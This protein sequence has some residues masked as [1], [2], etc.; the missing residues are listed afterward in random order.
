MTVLETAYLLL[1]MGLWPIPITPINDPVSVA[2]GKAP[3]PFKDW[4]K[5]KYTKESLAEVYAAFPAA[6]IGLK[7]GPEGKIIDIDVDDPAVG[8]PVV[9]RMMGGEVIETVGWQ[10][11]R[12]PHMVFWF[13][14]RLT[15]YGKS[16]IKD[17]PRYP[18]LELRFG[19]SS[20]GPVQIQSV[21]P[22]SLGNNG[23]PRVW[24]GVQ[25][26]AF[27]P[28]AFFNDLD[29][30]L[31]DQQVS[32]FTPVETV[33]VASTSSGS[34]PGTA[35]VEWA[36]TTTVDLEERAIAYLKK[37]NPSISGQKGH[38][39][40]FRIACTIGPGFDLP[41]DVA[42]RLLRDVWNPTCQPPWSEKELRHK[43]E[44]A[45][46]VESRPRGWL[47]DNSALLTTNGPLLA[48]NGIR[49]TS[50]STTTSG[51]IG[52]IDPINPRVV[53]E[54]EEEWE[55]PILDTA[56][57]VEPFPLDVLPSSLADLCRAGAR[58]LNCPVDYFAVAAL[59]LAGGVIGRTV[60]LKMTTTWELTANL[61]IAIV[62]PPGSK[63]SP[64][65]KIMAGPLFAIDRQLRDDYKEAKKN[66]KALPEDDRGPEPVLEHLTLDDTT[67]EAF[68]KILSDNERGLLLIKDELTAWV[69]DLNAY[70]GGKGSDRQFWMG[71]NTGSLVKVTRKG[72][73]EPLVIPHP[74]GAVV[75]CLTPATLPHIKEGQG[76]DGWLD[77]ILFA[78]PKTPRLAEEWNRYEV[79]QELLDEWRNAVG[80]LWSRKMTLDEGAT[81][82]RPWLVSLT[83]NGESRWS[84]FFKT[85]SLEQQDIDFPTS[86]V[87]PWSKYVGFTLRLSLVLSQL[88]QAYDP[89][90]Y[91]QSRN[92]DAMDVWGA[93]R[94]IAYFKNNFRRVRSELAGF[95]DLL[96][97]DAR[98]VLRWLREEKLLSFTAREVR[99]KFR[100]FDDRDRESALSNLVSCKVIRFAGKIR[101]GDRPGRSKEVYEVNPNIHLPQDNR[102]NS[103]NSSDAR[104][105]PGLTNALKFLGAF[106]IQ[107][108]APRH[109]VI[110]KA[111]E[112]HISEGDI[113][114]GAAVFGVEHFELNGE[115]HW[116]MP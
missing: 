4:G 30:Y 7:L 94:L 101:E 28:D 33:P 84:E 93:S 58:A 79:P 86:L 49:A 80:R 99:R 42:F 87:G 104:I 74:C 56:L 12:G 67:R 83:E 59:G 16:I 66:W 36:R 114:Q 61:F 48:G 82:P 32:L 103:A 68:A 50:N 41:P 69:A 31:L 64:A 55:Q 60:S 20:N 73:P 112:E 102:V 35:P 70:R 75:G 53:V 19:C 92:V 110:S 2:P 5:T 27:L 3:L 95:S 17:H 115:L 38:N 23:Q 6:G 1:D 52:P 65:L 15:K 47:R 91:D 18:G 97:D 98:A 34:T 22:P 106:L 116:R 54:K 51:P 29:R 10:S 25:E 24:N 71:L 9:E 108:P 89:T 90:C 72:S 113:E 21:V 81:H 62:G 88:H 43:I 76:D 26:I 78:F 77:R 85:N 45:Y 8:S 96:T 46:R 100:R 111:A 13:D 39:T 105:T 109:L 57:D 63:K 14:E 107:G 37:C 11:H 40:A 44:D